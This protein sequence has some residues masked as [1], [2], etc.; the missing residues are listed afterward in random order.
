MPPHN[1]VGLA[2][3]FFA[4]L[5]TICIIWN[6]DATRRLAIRHPDN[7]NY[8]F[9]AGTSFLFAPPLMDPRLQLSIEFTEL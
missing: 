7:C 5:A 9:F 8:L 1:I 2:R 3:V 6:T 4:A